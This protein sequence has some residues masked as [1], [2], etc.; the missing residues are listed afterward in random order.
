M[1]IAVLVNRINRK[2]S[3]ISGRKLIIGKSHHGYKLN[4]YM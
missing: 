2:A 4:P 3:L 1:Q